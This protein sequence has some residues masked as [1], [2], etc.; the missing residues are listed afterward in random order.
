MIKSVAMKFRSTGLTLTQDNNVDI[1][2]VNIL[3]SLRKNSPK[4]LPNAKGL[5]PLSLATP[6]S[7]DHTD[8]AAHKPLYA[9]TTLNGCTTEMKAENEM[10]AETE[11]KNYQISGNEVQVTTVTTQENELKMS[12]ME[13]AASALAASRDQS[14]QLVTVSGKY[15][16]IL[17]YK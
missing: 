8:T 3:K 1:H 7:K 11:T 4:K 10:E 13:A 16:S 6:T 9:A 12:T 17:F 5:A 15:Y 14:G 2:T